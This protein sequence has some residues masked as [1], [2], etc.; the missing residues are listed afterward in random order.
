MGGKD[1][2]RK[3]KLPL[4]MI[5]V[6]MNY[7]DLFLTATQQDNLCPVACRPQEFTP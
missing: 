3:R 7:W 2:T 6:G 1:W 5:E 4:E